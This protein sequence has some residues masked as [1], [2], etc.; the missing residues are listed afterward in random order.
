MK[1]TEYDVY[2][3]TFH[4]DGRFVAEVH[5]PKNADHESLI[6]KATECYQDAD[7]GALEN[8]DAEPAMIE[9]MGNPIW[10]HNQ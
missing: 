6:E 7:F 2:Y 8:I 10:T 5:A 3:V 1:N 4:I 9:N